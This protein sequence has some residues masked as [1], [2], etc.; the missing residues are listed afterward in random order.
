MRWEKILTQITATKDEFA[1]ELL[2][3]KEP[4]DIKMASEKVQK[5][6][7]LLLE[8]SSIVEKDPDS[9]GVEDK[10]MI[11]EAIE[12]FCKAVPIEF[13]TDPEFMKTHISGLSSLYYVT[14]DEI[15]LKKEYTKIRDVA[16]AIM[17]NT[18]FYD[19]LGDAILLKDPKV[20]LAALKSN[21]T[22][23]ID[24]IKHSIEEQLKKI[25]KNNTKPYTKREKEGKYCTIASIL[26]H[27]DDP[28]GSI[29]KLLLNIRNDAGFKAYINN[30][31]PGLLEKLGDDFKILK[32]LAEG[33]EESDRDN[34]ATSSKD[35]SKKDLDDSSTTAPS[36]TVS[37]QTIDKAVSNVER[38][39]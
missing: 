12:D 30:R 34:A 27:F 9:I 7:V 39:R 14:K 32:T 22:I 13:R 6:S 15:E 26:D 21:N 3:I 25:S 5:V 1:W 23:E 16:I 10:D 31:Q 24:N 36:R 28:K 19:S 37:S 17:E 2:N 8:A 33:S 29:P 35:Q 18:N 38:G 20:V 4:E 11:G